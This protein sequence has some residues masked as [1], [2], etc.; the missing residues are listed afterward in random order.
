MRAGQKIREENLDYSAVGRL[1]LQSVRQSAAPRQ[2][3]SG[4]SLGRAGRFT[5]PPQ[6][7]G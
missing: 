2:A 3:G 4:S 1:P 5:Q 6:N 7:H